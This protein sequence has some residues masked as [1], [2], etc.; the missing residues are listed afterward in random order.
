MQ[1]QNHLTENKTFRA[2]QECR[3]QIFL[4]WKA[5]PNPSENV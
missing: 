2:N 1:M 3:C 4:E 5:L